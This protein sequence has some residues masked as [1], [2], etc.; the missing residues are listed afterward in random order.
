MGLFLAPE[1]RRIHGA[2]FILLKR[3]ALAGVRSPDV[4]ASFHAMTDVRVQQLQTAL[5]SN[6]RE[7]SLGLAS[8]RRST[9]SR[10]DRKPTA[11][12]GEQCRRS[13]LRARDGSLQ[14]WSPWRFANR[15]LR[16]DPGVRL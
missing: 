7:C 8:N 13:E 9:L 16:G 11:P 15:P 14:P 1:A 2:K 5:A 6:L 3:L 4:A 12:A 10:C